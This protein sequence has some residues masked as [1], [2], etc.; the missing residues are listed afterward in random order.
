MNKISIDAKLCNKMW[1]KMPFGSFWKTRIWT[2]RSNFQILFLVLFYIFCLFLRVEYNNFLSNNL[3]VSD[4]KFSRILLQLTN[5]QTRSFRKIKRNFNW[6]NFILPFLFIFA[7]NI[8]PCPFV[9][10]VTCDI[11]RK[12]TYSMRYYF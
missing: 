8:I 6:K 4:Q 9:S 7:Y 2:W 3:L 1:N 12:K 10:L 5:I 11:L